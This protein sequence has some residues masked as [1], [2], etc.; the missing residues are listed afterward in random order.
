EGGAK[1]ARRG[2]AHALSRSARRATDSGGRRVV[3]RRQ[4]IG[5]RSQGLCLG[6][7]FEVRQARSRAD[8]FTGLGG[9][10][11]RRT[12]R[13]G[14]S[15]S[16]GAGVLREAQHDAVADAWRRLELV[17]S[18]KGVLVDRLLRLFPLFGNQ[19]PTLAGGNHGLSSSRLSIGSKVAIGSL[20]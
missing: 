4:D 11:T 8:G 3:R 6:R 18:K 17:R 5:R 1:G 13:A 16:R 15:S 9:A 7:A 10:Q 19:V 2:P 20:W 12:S 14:P